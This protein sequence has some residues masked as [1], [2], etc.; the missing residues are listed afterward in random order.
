MIHISALQ[1]HSDTVF[2]TMGTYT[3]E[4][5]DEFMGFCGLMDKASASGAEDCR[6]ESCQRRCPI[7]FSMIAERTFIRLLFSRQDCCLLIE[8]EYSVMPCR[9]IHPSY[10]HI[11]RGP[12]EP[13]TVLRTGANTSV[14]LLQAKQTS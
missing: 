9:H 14:T 7:F 11:L 8:S 3:P 1:V 13:K 2:F 10:I 12:S 6:F 5:V 4:K